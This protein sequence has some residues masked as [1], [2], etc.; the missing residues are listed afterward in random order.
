MIL[1]SFLDLQGVVIWLVERLLKRRAVSGQLGI[2][3][4]PEGIAV[5]HVSSSETGS[6]V[7]ESCR[8][9]PREKDESPPL[10]QYID[11]L[12]LKGAACNVILPSGSYSLLLTEAPEVEDDELVDAMRWRIN[13]LVDFPIE[14]AALDV[15]RLPDDASRGSAPMVYVV[16]S[17]S[18]LIYEILNLI[19]P[20]GLKLKSISIIELALR[21]L[22][23]LCPEDP[24]G[25]AIVQLSPGIGNLNVIK[26]HQ[27][28]LS[29][30]FDLD[31]SG[32]MLDPLPTNSLVLELQRSLD[33]YERQMGHVPPSCIYLCGGG[34]SSDKVTAEAQESIAAELKV[35]P[36]GELIE[37]P[38]GC[39]ELMLTNCI[40]AIGGALIAEDL[41]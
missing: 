13:D 9:L 38:E 21:N 35:F 5:A 16:A 32:G 41:L 39:D 2:E 36:L 15:F 40:G 28:Y 27:L 11:E 26:H 20:T 18:S 22:S 10:A 4:G 29:R 25:L 33:Y 24:E 7:L 1:N 34:V 8:F 17:K 12:E 14:D 19:K 37:L 6:P 31:F 23:M 30:H 3:I